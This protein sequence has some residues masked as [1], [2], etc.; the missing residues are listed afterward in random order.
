MKFHKLL[1][2]KLYIIKGSSVWVIRAFFI[3]IAWQA[4]VNQASESAMAEPG[5]QFTY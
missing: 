1:I 3:T 5:I 4:K 2:R